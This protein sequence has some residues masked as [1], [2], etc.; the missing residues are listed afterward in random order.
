MD[1]ITPLAQLSLR[2]FL[3]LAYIAMASF[4]LSA[5]DD[6]TEEEIFELSPFTIETEQDDGYQATATLAGT[7]VR[8]DLRDLASSISVV[9]EQFLKDTAATSNESLLIYTT[10]TEVGGAGGNFSGVGTSGEE[11]NQLLAPSTNTRIRGLSAADNTRN[12]F[13]TDIPWDSYNVDRVDLQRGPNS[14]LF[15]VGSPA[16]IIN[17]G[18]IIPFFDNEGEYEV[19]V[20]G[21]GSFRQSLDY[22]HSVIDDVF[23]VRIAALMDHEKFQQEPA[24]EDDERLYLSFVFNP[25]WFGEEVHTTI[26]GNFESGDIDANRPRMLPPVDAITP[27]FDPAG[28]NGRVWDP[29]WAWTYNA[30]I[31]RGNS[32]NVIPGYSYH[33]PWLGQELNKLLSR[34]PTMMI[35]NGQPGWTD[36]KTIDASEVFAINSTGDRD[37][38]ISGF[39]DITRPNSIAA[40]NEYTKNANAVNPG[41]FPGASKNYYRD[42]VLSDPSIFD[43]YNQ[44]IDG[45]N[46]REWSEWKAYNLSFS[47]TYFGN[48][49]G[50]EFVY[51]YQDLERGSEMLFDGGNPELNVDVNSHIEGTPTFYTITDSPVAGAFPNGWADPSTVTGGTINPNAG[52]ALIS[53]D[54][55]QGQIQQRERENLR[56]T[57]YAEINGSDF[58]EE[59]SFLAKLIGRN[60]FT[61]L[62][63]RDERNEFDHQYDLF[64]LA[65]E[66]AQ[67]QGEPISIGGQRGVAYAVYLSDDLR[68]RSSASGLNLSGLRHKIDVPS[69]A[70][71][72]Y[73]DSNWN[74]NVDPAAPYVRPVDGSIITQS[75]NPANYVGWT[76]AEIPV[77]SAARGDID[78]LTTG[79]SRLTEILES[80]ALTWQGYW[81]D[82]NLVPT[83]GWR[84]DKIESWGV[85]GDSDPQTN[86]TEYRFDNPK[87]DETLE[88]EGETVTWGIVGHLPEAWRQHLPEGM[89][90]SVF[91]NESEN[92]QAVNRVGFDGSPLPNPTGES[93][94]YGFVVS[95]L[96]N[97]LRFKV[98]WYETK[99]Q[100]AT[101]PASG[102]NSAELGPSN[103]FAWNIEGWIVN[104]AYKAERFLNG[105][106]AGNPGESNYAAADAGQ[107]GNPDW[108]SHPFP[109]EMLNH[110][111]Y[112]QQLAA[113]QHVYDTIAP[114]SFFDGYG[115]P[116]DVSAAQGTFEDRARMINGG[117]WDHNRYFADL[118][119]GGGGRINGLAPTS[120]INNLSEG[121]EFELIAQ[122]IDNWS[123]AINASKTEAK[124]TSLGEAFVNFVE[125]QKERFDGP[126]GDLRLWWGSDRTIREYYDDMIYQAYLFQQEANG[127]QSTEIRP[128]RFNLVTN[129]EFVDSKFEGANVGMALRWQDDAI[130]GYRLD[131]ED[132]L[133]PNDPIKGGAEGVVDAWVGYERRITDKVDWRIQLNMRNIGKDDRLV[134]ITVNPD[135]SPA[136]QRISQGMTWTLTNTFSF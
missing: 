126:S 124:R 81:F 134:P 31:D 93:K 119:P 50:W 113:I 91:Y 54:D 122:P 106:S 30:Q 78:E 35:N 24:F 85:S 107:S 12:Y 40:F 44:L 84:K 100:N 88:A 102:S 75:E 103:W 74:S 56:F 114:Q 89:D 45:D 132:R 136:A 52:R 79:A 2:G 110:P 18:T 55:G 116:V 121:V 73:F 70:V 109:D 22:N 19:R 115:F 67:L 33:A 72:R 43:F 61:G 112:I 59:E 87:P 10:N 11:G 98:T 118:Q 49:L 76:Q 46:K 64:G 16:G 37:Q 41:S 105:L 48:R 117:D 32:G 133:N 83:V 1:K 90:L 97:R 128:W 28:N 62:I 15:G 95:A 17:T 80:Q 94:D 127:T 27:F 29:A 4:S 111:T 63:A 14:I 8:T 58:F 129:Y 125:G 20:D 3:T 92:F 82:G 5:Q 104:K 69:T 42:K 86:V 96:D 68:G 6:D 21:E 25:D 65:P 36:F 120:T 71:V 26:R 23:A 60:V 9:T 131:D 47:Q 34:A 51:D 39:A 101:N 123:I 13:V 108:N 130:L 66:I 99:L 135:G 7:R 38:Q 53:D 77:Y 57:A